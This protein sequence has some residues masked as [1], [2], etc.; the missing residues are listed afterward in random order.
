MAPRM[1]IDQYL[2]IA[3][4]VKTGQGDNRSLRDVDWGVVRGG[5]LGGRDHEFHGEGNRQEA[6]DPCPTSG[7]KFRRA[8]VW[9][10]DSGFSRIGPITDTDD[11]CQTPIIDHPI[12]DLE[13]PLVHQLVL[14]FGRQHVHGI[15]NNGMGHG[16]PL[17]LFG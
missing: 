2:Q 4:V 7:R 5:D 8:L 1:A 9:S 15:R 13:A 12:V 17:V 6:S 10:H 16:L 14:R 11:A 3:V